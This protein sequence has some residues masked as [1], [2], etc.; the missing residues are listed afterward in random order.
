MLS[1]CQKVARDVRRVRLARELSQRQLGQLAGFAQPYLCQVE[2]GVRA[3]SVKAA[4]KLELALEL[5]EGR[6]CKPLRNRE[7]RKL[8]AATRA[9]L[10]DFGRQIR[11]FV[12][13]EKP[14]V[15]QPHQCF[16]LENP[17]WPMGVHLGEEAAEEVRQLELLRKNQPRFWR[18]FNSF[19]FD[20]WSEKRLL[21]RVALLGMQL[22]GVRL[23]QLGCSLE[24]VDGKTGKHPGLHR[25]FVHKGEGASLVWCP[26]VAVRAGN[27][28]LCVDNLLL[29]RLGGKTVTTVVEVNGAPFHAD[30]E[31]ERRRNRLLGVPILHLD[32]C[33]LGEPRLIERILSWARRV[34]EAA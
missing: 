11:E 19:R 23:D 22:T 10:R 18:D 33:R 28:V 3:I 15:E 31:K 2:K 27:T 13:G 21:V 7:S 25:A 9:A 8:W 12:K 20:S 29:I 16:S 30:Q 5:K 17:L 34:A 32:A 6:F 24:L 1:P 26:Q 14:W 4:R